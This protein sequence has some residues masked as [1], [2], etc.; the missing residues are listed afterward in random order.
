[1]ATIG[2]RGPY[3]AATVFQVEPL[4]LSEADPALDRRHRQKRWWAAILKGRTA[5]KPSLDRGLDVI[6][7]NAKAQAKLIEDML[8]ASRI[9]AGMLRLEYQPLILSELI[10]HAIEAARPAAERKRLTFTVDLDRGIP[11]IP[12]DPDRLRQIHANLLS[13]AIKFTPE[14]GEVSVVLAQEGTHAKMVV[15]G[16]GGWNSTRVP[17]PRVR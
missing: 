3:R 6:E 12:G 16:Y 7:R 2:I 13:N 15:K 4:D 5:G 1:V 11:P 9:V 8:D 17:A 10:E 14:G